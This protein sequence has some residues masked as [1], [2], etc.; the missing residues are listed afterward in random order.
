[1]FS[2]IEFVYMIYWSTIDRD[3]HSVCPETSMKT[4]GEHAQSE[5]FPDCIYN[6]K[7]MFTCVGQTIIWTFWS[8]GSGKNIAEIKNKRDSVT[9]LQ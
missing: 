4:R 7:P 9:V 8:L 5:L 3:A 6:Y 1:M 2:E